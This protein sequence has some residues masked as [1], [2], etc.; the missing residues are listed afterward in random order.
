[1]PIDLSM[2]GCGEYDLLGDLLAGEALLEADLSPFDGLLEPALS[3][4]DGDLSLL[5]ADLSLLEGLLDF[6]DPL[7]DGLLLLDSSD[8]VSDTLL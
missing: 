8:G 4:S 2:P 7:L 5:D 3:L 6:S 1:M